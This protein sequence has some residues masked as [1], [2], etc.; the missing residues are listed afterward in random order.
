MIF[1]VFQFKG[2]VWTF[3]N[4][5]NA[6]NLEQKVTVSWNIVGRKT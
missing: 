4:D 6:A 3:L 1:S 5:V 2:L